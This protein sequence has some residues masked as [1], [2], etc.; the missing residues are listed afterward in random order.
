MLHVEDLADLI[1]M[2]LH[3]P[4]QFR[5]ETY[6]VGGGVELSSSLL[7]LTEWCEKITGQSI[8]IQN[9]PESRPGDIPWFITDT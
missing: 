4:G 6:N 9:V 8:P 2:Q 1:E 5:G 3:Q 7:E